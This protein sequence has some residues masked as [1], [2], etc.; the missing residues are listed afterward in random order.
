[1]LC[2]IPAL[3]AL[4]AGLP[5]A[6]IS[7][8]ALPWAS[9]L[10]PRFGHYFDEVIEFPGWPGLPERE[11]DPSAVDEFKNRMHRR[12]FDLALQLHGDGSVSNEVMSA[13]GARTIAGFFL[14]GEAPPGGD[15]IPYPASGSEPQRLLQLMAHLGFDPL[16]ADLEFPLLASDYADLRR[17]M[18]GLPELRNYAV[19]HAGSRSG[20]RR[21][22]THNF[23]A[24]ADA[25]IDEGL[26]VVLTGSREEQPLTADVARQMN[27]L[28]FDLVGRTTL[29]SLA[30]LIDGARV[31]VTNDTGVS[32]VCA[33]RRTPSV[34][35]FSG[36]D[37]RRWAP[38]D[39][40]RHRV[41]LAR[42]P[43]ALEMATG[44]ARQFAHRRR[45]P[46]EPGA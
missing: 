15:F 6:R 29:G 21:W 8:I 13:L 42:S 4:R 34:V 41:V 36:S 22:P 14:D 33:A 39:A 11:F 16:S 30:V 7:L 3:R 24:V 17:T 38:A 1:M 40:A 18:A 32:H 23:A 9:Q 28:A 37:H 5:A 43:H 25:L 19:V 46:T 2:A 10:L 12:R 45:E 44:Y 20:A 27:G 31:V 26:T 35:V